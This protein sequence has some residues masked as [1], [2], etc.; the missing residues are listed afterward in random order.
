MDAAAAAVLLTLALVLIFRML[1]LRR[2]TPGAPPCV[3]GWIPW[4]GAAFELGKAPLQFIEQARAKHGPIFTVLAAGNRMTFVFDEEG[5][6]AF[7]TSKQV[8]FAQAVQK[9]V[10]YTASITKENF[11]KGHNDI[12]VLMKSRLSQSNLHLYMKNLCEELHRH[13]ESLGTEGTLDLYDIVRHAM[14]PAVVDTLFGKGICPT[15]ESTLKEFKEHFQT[16]DE[17]FEHGSQLPDF[18]LR[19]WS[20]SKYWLLKVFEKVVQ[21]AERTRPSDHDSKTLLQHLLDTL[22]G[23]STHNNSMLLLWASQANAN[24]ITFWTL[25]FIISDASLYEKV[26]EELFGVFGKTGKKKIEITEEDLKAL[27][28]SKSCVLE[29][30][31]LRAPGAIA[32][33]VVQPIKINNYIVPEGDMLML[34]P[35][36]VHRNPKYF[37]EPEKFQPE[38]WKKANLGKN[39]F[40][41]GFVAFGGGRYQCPGRWF[42]LM[43]IHLVLVSILYRFEFVMLDPVPKQSNSHLVGTQQP[44]GPCRVNYKLRV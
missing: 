27:P 23:N 10:Q 16:F 11:Y 9:P 7:F 1:V 38:R 4:L 30:I 41:D 29:T 18:L 24:P 20:K 37:S 32:R 40:L 5:M 2:G 6:S 34:S 25:A 13:M 39:V 14:Y 3:R 26:M 28:F 8:D 15:S 19:N 36:W 17:G 43:E 42:A 12:H 35:Y 21:D 33:K 22:K 44:N 31:R